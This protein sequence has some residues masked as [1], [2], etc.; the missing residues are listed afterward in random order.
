MTLSANEMP[1]GKTTDEVFVAIGFESLAA[2][3]DQAGTTP[4]RS[5]PLT[6]PMG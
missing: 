6:G 2:C 5:R 4:R 3:Y 1:A